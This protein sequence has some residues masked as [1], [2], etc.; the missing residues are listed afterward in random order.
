MKLFVLVFFLMLATTACAAPEAT[1][2]PPPEVT[3][4]PEPQPLSDPVATVTKRY[5]QTAQKETSAVMDPAVTPAYVRAVR[6]ADLVA[7]QALDALERQ[8]T[9]TGLL[10]ARAAVAK[11]EKVLDA[12]P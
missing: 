7:R 9:P 8:P 2:L 6:E 1:P 3:Q 5:Q 12:T 4:A 11:L 10:R